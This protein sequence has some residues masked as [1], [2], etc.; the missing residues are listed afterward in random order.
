MTRLQSSC[1][2][3]AR[4]NTAG[5]GDRAPSPGEKL[6]RSPPTRSKASLDESCFDGVNPSLN[7]LTLNTV[8]RGHGNQEPEIDSDF[9]GKVLC[10]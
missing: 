4:L 6:H 1:R 7:S 10:S 3:K 5:R 8:E 2:G 9:N